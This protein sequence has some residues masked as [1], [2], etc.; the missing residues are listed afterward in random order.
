MADRLTARDKGVPVQF[1]GAQAWLPDSLWRLAAVLGAPVILCFGLY[2]GGN[3]YELHFERFLDARAPTPRQE[4]QVFVQQCAQRYAECLERRVRS[5][6]YNW[7]N[8][9]DFWSDEP[10]RDH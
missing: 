7:F 4:R 9:Y 1:L 5:A 6:P 3:H 10:S 8:F 2:R